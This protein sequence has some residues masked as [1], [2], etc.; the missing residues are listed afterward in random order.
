MPVPACDLPEQL[1]WKHKQVAD[2]VHRL[3]GFPPSVVAPVIPCPQPYGYR[4][5][6]MIRSQWNRPE[7]RLNLGFLRYDNRL[8]VD[9]ESCAIAEPALND[10]LRQVRAHPPPK[11]DSRSCSASPLPTGNCPAI[12][13]SRTTF[14]SSPNSS[15]PSGPDSRPPAR[16]TLLDAYCGI[17]FFALEL[18][19][20][21]ES[22]LGVE[23]DTAAIHAARRN[24]ANRHITNGEF[25]VGRTEEQLADLLRR[26]DPARTTVLLDPPRTGCARPAIEALHEA[27]PAQ[28]LYV[29]CH[30]ATLARDLKA[31]CADQRFALDL[32]QPLD[33]FPKRSTSSASPTCVAAPPDKELFL[34]PQSR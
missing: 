33:M 8:V 34:R 32:V 11:A 27:A 26:G 25:V 29:S 24:A 18:A 17:G 19:P 7:Q 21:V 6:I 13:F 15:K 28:I 10:Q 16:A 2:L 12:P 14:T 1:R 22:F 3:G 4:N 31:L 23:L 9:L 20:A 30:P 5:R